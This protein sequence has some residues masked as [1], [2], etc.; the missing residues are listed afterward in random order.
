MFL[1]TALKKRAKKM[2]SKSQKRAIK[3][4][5]YS[6]VYSNDLRKLALAF[7]TDKE[8]THYYTQHYQHHFSQLRRSNIKLLEIGIGGDETPEAGGESLRMWKAYFKNGEIFG[9]DI[10]DKTDH[11]E[12]R[13]KTFKG[14]QVDREF[15]KKVVAETGGFDIVIDDGSHYNDHVVDTFNILFPLVKSNGIYV[16]EDLQT[17]YWDEMNGKKWGGSNDLKAEYTSMNFLKSLVDGLNYEEFAVDN[18]VPTYFDKNI[19]SIHFYHNLAFIYKGD[20]NEGSNKLGKKLSK[21]IE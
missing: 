1:S 13:I 9:I 10:F 6:L 2:L 19:I 4:F 12:K 21:V 20:N 15:L 16:I 11:D 18:Y 3:H 5:V 17:S 8:G 14:N 7:G